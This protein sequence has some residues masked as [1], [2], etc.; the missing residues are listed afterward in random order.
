[1][2]ITDYLIKK[3]Q[4]RNI[5]TDNIEI[6]TYGL[7]NGFTLII[8]VLTAI[9]IS[10]IVGHIDILFFLLISFVPLRSY[11]GGFHCKSRLICYFCSNI[12]VTLLLISQHF[13]YEHFVVFSIISFLSFIFLFFYKTKGNQVRV[14]DEIEIIHYT[15][16]K[17]VILFL[18]IVGSIIM[19]VLR[20]PQYATTMES[21][22]IVVALLIL[23]ENLRDNKLIHTSLLTIY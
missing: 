3:M 14:L 7:N 17:R 16:I 19:I 8:N 9:L 10:Y 18:I 11:C 6:Y 22:I 13:F 23:A 21:S 1:M 4:Q 20:K 2:Q 15:K 12:I 5:I